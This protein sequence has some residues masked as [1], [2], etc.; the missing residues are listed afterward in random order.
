M[1]VIE[2]EREIELRQQGPGEH[3]GTAHHRQHQR[4][5]VA[6][7]RA[8]FTGNAAYRQRRLL[9]RAQQVGLGQDAARVIGTHV[10]LFSMAANSRPTSAWRKPKA[11]VASR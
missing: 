3:H 7:P 8:D 5:G 9:C 10:I 11:T 4:I 1:Q 2:I 6:Q